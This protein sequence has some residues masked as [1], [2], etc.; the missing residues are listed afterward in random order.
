M[1]IIVTY[2]VCHIV[3]FFLLIILRETHAVLL[4][5]HQQEIKPIF[6]PHGV[7]LLVVVSRKQ[8]CVLCEP[9]TIHILA[10]Q[11]LIVPHHPS[12]L[13]RVAPRVLVRKT[14][15]SSTD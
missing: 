2:I 6:D 13:D 3:L 12:C 9:T 14:M 8:Q 15:N 10:E 1:H 7:N 4:Q 11:P 5:E